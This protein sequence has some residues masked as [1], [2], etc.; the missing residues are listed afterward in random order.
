MQKWIS[1]SGETHDVCVLLFPRFSNHCLANAI[2]P[3]RATNV[4]LTRE[5]YRWRFVTLDGE[6]V[7]SSSGLPVMPQARLRDDPGGDFLFVMSSYDVTDFAGP[8]TSRA[9]Q[10]AARRVRRRSSGWTPGPG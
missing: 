9:L 3:F 6:A 10:A 5:A 7:V 2:E 4:L 1:G 8:A